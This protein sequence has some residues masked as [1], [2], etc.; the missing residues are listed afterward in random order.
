MAEP[1]LLPVRNTVLYHSH[2]KAV[3]PSIL[4]LVTHL[5]FDFQRPLC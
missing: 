3:L 4:L 2:Q 5:R 1:G